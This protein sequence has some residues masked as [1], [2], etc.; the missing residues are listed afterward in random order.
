MTVRHGSR[1]GK[2]LGNNNDSNI[3]TNNN[4]NESAFILKSPTS[5]VQQ[6]NIIKRNDHPRM[7][8]LPW[9]VGP[10]YAVMLVQVQ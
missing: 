9:R 7:A 6:T 4:N 5:Q 8:S 3:N 2:K 1:V 10:S